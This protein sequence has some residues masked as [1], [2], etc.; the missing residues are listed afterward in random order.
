MLYVFAANTHANAYKY[1]D[2]PTLKYFHTHA[3]DDLIFVLTHV[4]L[5]FRTATIEAT[6][7]T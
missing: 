1:I 3:Y 5:C 7:E 2:S 4:Y 6:T